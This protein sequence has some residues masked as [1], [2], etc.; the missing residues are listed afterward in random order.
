MQ[1]GYY[2]YHYNLEEDVPEGFGCII[3]FNTEFGI[4]KVD[5]LPTSPYVVGIFVSEISEKGISGKFLINTE[6]T[7]PAIGTIRLNGYFNFE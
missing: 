4:V 1:L 7:H 2:E 6:S 5:R 3:A